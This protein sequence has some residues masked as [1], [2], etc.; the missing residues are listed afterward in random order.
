MQL[1]DRVQPL[2]YVQMLL[3][4]TFSPSMTTCGILG[5]E[6][7]ACFADMITDCHGAAERILQENLKTRV[8]KFF[9]EHRDKLL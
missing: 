2:F 3:S 8:G 5:T 7:V 1:P 4:C 9:E 6:V